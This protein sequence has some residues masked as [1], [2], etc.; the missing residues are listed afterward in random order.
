[1]LPTHFGEE[2]NIKQVHGIID[3]R[4]LRP[5]SKIAGITRIIPGVISWRKKTSAIS[6]GLYFQR[7]L[8]TGIKMAIKKNMYVQDVYVIGTPSEI[9]WAGLKKVVMNPGKVLPP[10]S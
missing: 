7:C 8:P 6:A 9:D 5:L 3:E 2:P 1:L 10:D 4:A